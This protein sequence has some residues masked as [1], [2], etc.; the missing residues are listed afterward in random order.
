M[1]DIKKYT[2][3]DGAVWCT[4]TDVEELLKDLEADS[5]DLNRIAQV[6]D[7]DKDV[8]VEGIIKEIRELQRQLAEMES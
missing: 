2:D 4:W 6:L 3:G 1:R 7:I 5:H 8:T